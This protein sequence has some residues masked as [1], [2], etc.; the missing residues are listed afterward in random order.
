VIGINSQ[1]ATSG[2]SQGNVGIGF[3]VP[4]NTVRQV[5]PIL[6]K[7][8]TIKRAYLGVETQ[9]PDTRAAASGAQVAT[10]VPGGPAQRAGMQNGDVI[11]SVGGKRVADPTQLSVVI[12]AKQP[13][14][15]VAVVVKRSG[16]TRTLEVT[17]G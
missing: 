9:A 2:S 10:M 3:A 5:V 13:G 1:I 4:A 11:Q 15:R 6:K 12:S 17:L 14:D 7:G 16:S 8:G